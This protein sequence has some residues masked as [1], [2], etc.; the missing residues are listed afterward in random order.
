MDCELS[1]H[2]IDRIQGVTPRH[3]RRLYRSYRD[4]MPY[5]LEQD[6]VYS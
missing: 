2:R 6:Y 5:K 1:P 3:V 4:I